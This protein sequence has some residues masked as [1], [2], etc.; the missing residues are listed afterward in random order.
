MSC[1]FI[2]KFWLLMSTKSLSLQ[3][4]WFI[5][6][7]YSLAVLFRVAGELYGDKLILKIIYIKSYK[8]WTCTRLV[9]WDIWVLQSNL[10]VTC[11]G[12]QVWIVYIKNTFYAFMN[13]CYA[14]ECCIPLWILLR[15][16]YLSRAGVYGQPSTCSLTLSIY[17]LLKFSNMARI[18]SNLM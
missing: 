15:L 1:F 17:L 9:S 16:Q 11:T 2:L 10:K 7:F 18:Y 12:R 5:H 13:C 14:T 4:Y 3:Q 8:I 6:Q